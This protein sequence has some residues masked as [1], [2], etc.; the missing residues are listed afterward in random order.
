MPSARH[1]DPSR[2]KECTAPLAGGNGLKDATSRRSP[3]TAMAVP[4]PS[5]SAGS[6]AVSVPDSTQPPAPRV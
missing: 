4:K 1:A 2:T 6:G 5:P 3:E